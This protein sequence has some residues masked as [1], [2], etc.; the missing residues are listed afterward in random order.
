MLG[1]LVTCTS[2]HQGCTGG[3][4]ER[5]LTIAASTHDVYHL[6]GFEAHR[7]TGFQQAFPKAQDFIH[8][9]S[10]HLDTH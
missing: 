2:H 4:V 10:T 9:H 8:G 3:D 7:H 6:V 5:V 1:H